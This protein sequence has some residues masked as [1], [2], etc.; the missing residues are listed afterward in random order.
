MPRRRTSTEREAAGGQLFLFPTAEPDRPAASRRLPGK[1]PLDPAILW[2]IFDD[3]N[4][5]FFEGGLA[6]DIEWSERMTASAG[7]CCRAE[8]RIRISA[9]YHR[10]RPDLLEATVAHEMLHLI[11]PNH[12]REFRIVGR[13]IAAELGVSWREFRYPPRRADLTRYRYLYACPVCGWEL[14]SKK[15]RSVSCGFCHPSGFDERFRLVLT[16]SRARP[17][18]VLRGERP[19]RR[20]R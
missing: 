9:P 19:V 18:P 7:S 10:R 1:G 13:R 4:E 12:G 17:G 15:I 16:E 2:R 6:G 5:R 14:P 8:C 20:G 3:L 11:I